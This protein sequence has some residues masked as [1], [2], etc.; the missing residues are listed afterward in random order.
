MPCHARPAVGGAAVARVQ[1]STAGSSDPS[2][3]AIPAG[4]AG[5]PALRPRR[6]RGVRP[7][8]SG[9]RV[10]APS[11]PLAARPCRV[12]CLRRF[13]R[14]SGTRP[15]AWPVSARAVSHDSR[16]RRAVVLPRQRGY[17]AGPPYS[18][19]SWS[20]GMVTVSGRFSPALRTSVPRSTRS[21]R[22]GIARPWAASRAFSAFPRPPAH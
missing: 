3:G 20:F 13:S 17:C 19:R 10:R 4:F 8:A 14:I 11:Q 2:T 21:C 1:D 12:G 9:A 18:D 16:S 15:R 7:H 22:K 6:A 5:R